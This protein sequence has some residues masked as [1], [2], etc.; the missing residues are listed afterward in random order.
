MQ[1]RGQVTLFI[2]VGIVLVITF[3]GL[4]YLIESTN[5]ERIDIEKEKVI[6]KPEITSVKNYV[7]SC[8]ER[9]SEDAI[10]YVSYRGGYYNVPEPTVDNIFLRLPLYFDNGNK[11]FP[12]KDIIS[13]EIGKYILDKLPGCFDDFK[14]FKDQNIVVEIDKMEIEVILENNVL[15]ELNSPMTITK[16]ES[17]TELQ[18]FKH[19]LSLDFNNVYSI[20]DGIVL[21]QEKNLNFVPIGYLSVEAKE[22]DF[23]FELSYLDDDVVVYSNIFNKYKVDRENYVFIFASS[24]DWSDLA[25]V[26]KLDYV[27]EV[28]DQYCY[29]GDKCYYNLNIYND[30][31]TFEDYTDLFDI[32]SNGK[33][34]FIPQQKDLGKHNV[35]VKVSDNDG[36]EEMVSF[37]LEIISLNFENEE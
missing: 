2:I 27:Q 21:E 16:G 9:T 3:I 37:K 32:S 29:V 12:T 28:E 20:I 26:K 30:P 7:Q 25:A 35:L 33:I 8:F 34:N 18:R 6:S 15:F 1:K 19:T 22:K 4:F 10:T 11:I 24:Y 23:N 31:F 17:K 36:N 5:K 13:N 14:V